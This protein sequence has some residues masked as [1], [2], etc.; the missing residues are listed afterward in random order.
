MEAMS[1]INSDVPNHSHAWK[2]SWERPM[3]L[4]ED[5]MDPFTVARMTDHNVRGVGNDTKKPTEEKTTEKE[6]KPE[7]RDPTIFRTLFMSNLFFKT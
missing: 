7:R 3:Y 2:G 1:K 6:K 5:S 4:D